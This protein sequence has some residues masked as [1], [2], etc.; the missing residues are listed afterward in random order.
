MDF[1]DE[2]WRY[3]LLPFYLAAYQRGDKSYQIV[4]NGQTGSI[5][6]QRP[7]DWRRVGVIVA[8]LLAAGPLLYIFSVL[9]LSQ[10]SDQASTVA[11]L[12]VAITVIGIAA[13]LTI[14][15]TAAKLDDA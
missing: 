5:A 10:I 2:E 1:A 12:A 4:V 7:A 3:L 8:A 15:A 13:A 6:G 14:L 9:G 11:C